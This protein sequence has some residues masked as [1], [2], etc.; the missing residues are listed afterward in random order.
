V[1]YWPWWLSPVVAVP[2]FA[3]IAERD[4]AQARRSAERAT[5]EAER[6]SE[7]EAR[8]AA[9]LERARIA[10]EIHDVLGHSLSGIAIQL[11]MAD[12]LHSGGREAEANLAT[13]RAR[14]LAVGSITETRRAIQA[15]REDTLPLT[16]TLRLLALAEGVPF[17]VGGE[18]GPVAV[19][20]AQTVIR[21]AQE[22]LTNSV[23]YASGGPRTM[24]LDFTGDS[25]ALTVTNGP[26]AAAGPAEIAGG[27]GMGLVGM[28]ERAALLGGTLRAGPAG[29]GWSVE[30]EVPK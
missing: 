18:A 4:R 14:A 23:K 16:E 20:T 9:L 17:E 8:E 25:V 7:S 2:V 26:G 21:V 13:R 15:L 5:A 1:L 30:L 11:D 19:E 24:K 12:A 27:T 28:R 10:R 6:A 3:G 29:T 22:A